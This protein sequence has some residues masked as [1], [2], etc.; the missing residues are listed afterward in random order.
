ML[1]DWIK[2]ELIA[3]FSSVIGIALFMF[4]KAIMSR[5]YKGI[6]F[7]MQDERTKTLTDAL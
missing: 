1:F 6:K 4:I 5:F 3:F 7:S 2:V